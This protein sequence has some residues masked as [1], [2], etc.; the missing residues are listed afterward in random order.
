MIMDKIL[1]YGPLCLLLIVV[2]E[3]ICGVVLLIKDKIPEEWR[4]LEE[5]DDANHCKND[6]VPSIVIKLCDQLDEIKNENR[7]LRKAFS[8]YLLDCGY[9]SRIRRILIMNEYLQKVRAEA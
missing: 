4:K 1:I 8:L 5:E 6:R 3:A 9:V 7:F 2:V